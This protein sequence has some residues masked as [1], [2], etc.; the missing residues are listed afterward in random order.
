MELRGGGAIVAP[1]PSVSWFY[2]PPTF[3]NSHKTVINSFA[4]QNKE[5]A[6]N[7]DFCNPIS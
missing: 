2:S 6:S 4:I 7:Y 5:I 3:S 1:T